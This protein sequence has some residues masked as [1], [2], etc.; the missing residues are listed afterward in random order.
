M[1]VGNVG[2][3][4]AAR[5]R[6]IFAAVWA[7]LVFSSGSG[8]GFAAE[9]VGE[10][11]RVRKSVTANLPGIAPRMLTV[12]EAVFADEI[13][14]TGVAARAELRLADGTSLTLGENAQ[15]SLDDFIYDSDGPT[16]LNL[17]IGAARFISGRL[18]HA[19]TMILRTPVAT[20]GVRGTDFWVGPIDGAIG[21]LLLDGE[22]EVTNAGGTIT[23]DEPRTGTLIYG[24]DIIPGSP[25]RWPDQRRARALSQTGFN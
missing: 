17:I 24:A 10:V 16:T 13:V 25:A 11:E 15:L 12:E 5:I 7:C 3:S 20:I 8:P 2:R 19:R 22:V 9:Q 14:T 21:V 4:P 1:E 18:G 6:I 23:L